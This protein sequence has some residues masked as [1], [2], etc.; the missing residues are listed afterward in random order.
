M[1]VR[2][3]RAIIS[4]PLKPILYPRVHDI[5]PNTQESTSLY[6]TSSKILF[7]S[8]GLSVIFFFLR[9]IIWSLSSK[10]FIS[11]AISSGTR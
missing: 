8:I 5:P 7:I 6:Q 11:N 2:I 1:I 4:H 10:P 3:S 9:P